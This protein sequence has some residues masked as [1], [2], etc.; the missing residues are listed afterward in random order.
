M[1]CFWYSEVYSLQ[2][3]FKMTPSV[4]AECGS[5]LGCLTLGRFSHSRSNQEQTEA[6]EARLG[7]ASPDASALL[8]TNPRTSVTRTRFPLDVNVKKTCT[9]S[10]VLNC[11]WHLTCKGLYLPSLPSEPS[12]HPSIHY[13]HWITLN[14]ALS[15]TFKTYRSSSTPCTSI[16][17]AFTSSGR[18]SA[19]NC[20]QT[21]PCRLEKESRPSASLRRSSP[22]SPPTRTSRSRVLLNW[23]CRRILFYLVQLS[24]KEKKA[25]LFVTAKFRLVAFI[26]LLQMCFKNKYF[27]SADHQ[28]KDRPQPVCQRIPG[29]RPKQVHC[30]SVTHPDLL[31]WG[32][33]C[34]AVNC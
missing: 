18:T 13:T 28:T 7:P 12:T 4:V 27:V 23:N 5:A 2:P 9:K 16:S 1:Q 14:A 8:W 3:C 25:M 17:L 15:L 10:Q 11:K 30:K 32:N 34:S 22:Q 21:S 20:P 26:K 19:A 33:W 31:S 6:P 24:P 29:L